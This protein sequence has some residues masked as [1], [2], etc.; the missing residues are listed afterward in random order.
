MSLQAEGKE[1]ECAQW[2]RN[3]VF[4]TTETEREPRCAQVA[5]NAEGI[6]VSVRSSRRGGIFT[7]LGSAEATSQILGSVWS[8]HDQRDIEGL[9]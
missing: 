4:G 6:L 1:L 9:E 8:C 2:E 5:K 3:W 7:V